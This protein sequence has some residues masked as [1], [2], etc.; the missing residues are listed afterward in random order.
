M[1]VL[2]NPKREQMITWTKEKWETERKIN[3]L[4]EIWEE[5]FEGP[6]I[7]NSNE[8]REFEWKVKMKCIQV[9]F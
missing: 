3:I 5:S 4:K 6:K 8:L 9:P 2:Q 1:Q 7:L